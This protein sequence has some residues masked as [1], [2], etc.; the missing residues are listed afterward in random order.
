MSEVNDIL[1]NK[2]I[3]LI[4]KK[5]SEPDEVRVFEKGRF[6][7]LILPGM[8]IGRATYKP[9][10]IWSKD[11]SPLSETEFCTV[12]H[13]GMVLEGSATVAF[14]NEGVKTLVA[15]DVFY[16]PSKPHDSWVIGNEDYISIHFLGAD[17]YATK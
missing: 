1:N 6:E 8:T 3:D 12:E 11:V 5:F 17:S 13:L 7:L 14:S 9:G 10:W 15:G 16:V 4:I 2:M